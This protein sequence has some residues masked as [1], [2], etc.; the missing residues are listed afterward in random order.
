MVKILLLTLLIIAFCIAFL[1]VGILVKKN[2]RFP[3]THVG[4]NKALRKQGVGCVMSQD[5][6][7]RHKK[8]GVKEREDNHIKK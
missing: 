2:G 4:G 1:S 6:E 7:M 3:N 8:G 5:F